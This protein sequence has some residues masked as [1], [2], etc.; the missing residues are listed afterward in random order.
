MFGNMLYFDAPKISEY[1]A[2]VKGEK[3]IKIGKIDVSSGKDANIKLPIAG[4][5]IKTSRS[6]EATIEES[7]LFDCDEFEKLLI[8]R[9]D[10]F[11]F[12][13]EDY[14]L[15]TLGR[16]YIIKFESVIREPEAF[17]M[18][19]TISQ[20]KPYIE[21]SIVRDMGTDEQAAFKLF[22]ET[23]NPKIPIICECSDHVLCAKMDS[24]FLKV[25]YPQLEEFE[26]SEVTILARMISSNDV[27]KQKAIFDPLKDFI[28]LNR[29]IRRSITND[30]P[31]GLKELFLDEE[32]RN[33]EVLAI[34]Q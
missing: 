2:I 15:S 23:K 6:Y 9:D 29:A 27:S 1:R 31:D 32:Y 18:T 26:S 4:G 22:F 34:Y 12:T 7:A 20:F 8:G 13:K 33:I 19:Q 28:S 5:D 24:K 16:G 10:Y 25:E 21:T 3:N 30:R 11:D 17:D 14:D